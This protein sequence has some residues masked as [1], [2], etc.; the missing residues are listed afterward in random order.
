MTVARHSI[1]AK[2]GQPAVLLSLLL[3]LLLYVKF[4][5]STLPATGIVVLLAWLYRDPDREIPSRPLSIVSPVDGR[6][7][8]VEHTED[9]FLKRQALHICI[10]MSL[11]GVFSLRSLTEG[12]V[13]QIWQEANGHGKCLAI[14][15]QTDEQDDTV[16]VLR[17]GRWLKR[18]SYQL[19]YGDRVGH[20]QRIGHILFGNIIDVYLPASARSNIEVGQDVKAGC[21]GI[22]EL[23]RS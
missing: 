14:W 5:P 18:L 23:M 10:D 21:D 13:M 11:A 9:R 16:L 7:L 20:G 1:L 12:K 8:S 6:V 17:P 19:A 22:A 4:G 15:I 3:I 2:E